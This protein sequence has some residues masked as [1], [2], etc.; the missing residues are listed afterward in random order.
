MKKILSVALATI[1]A[2]SA[3]AQMTYPDAVN[4]DI[5]RH[6]MRYSRGARTEIVLPQVNGY[7]IYKADLHTHSA[8]S[9]GSVLP[10]YRVKEAWIDGLDVMAVTEHI[11]YRRQESKMLEYLQDYAKKGE[12]IDNWD[13][14]NKP[15]DKKG[16]RVDL[17]YAV[18][19]SQKAAEQYGLLIIPGTE[20]TRNP[21]QIGHYNALF[22]T[23]NNAIY[24]ADPLQSFRN[25]KAQGALIQ[26]NH[27]G[28]QRKSIDMPEFEVKAYAE[29]LIDGIEIMNGSDFYPGAIDRAKELGLFMSANTDIHGTTAMDYAN[30]EVGRNMTL[31]FAKE[32]T[33]EAMREALE[34]RR[35][36]AYAFG[37]VAGDEQ[38]LKDFFLACVK[39]EPVMKDYKNRQIFTITN[40][41]SI[42]FAFRIGGGNVM[43]LDPFSTISAKTNNVKIT[44]ENMW[45][46]VDKHPVVEI[47][48]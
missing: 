27:P 3:S 6:S 15:A 19:L 40:T 9:D 23:D 35:T 12:E 38:L 41:S 2:I 8:F 4:K 44:V 36:L 28:W 33:L 32:K 10:E 1:A 14:I 46:G 34:A 21:Q 17:N 45:Y 13:I 48:F 11:E 22:T 24:D 47:N 43:W 37:N 7:N 20:I 42:P 31:I 5:N 16:I 30:V 39:F 18:T 26:H 25:A 29:G